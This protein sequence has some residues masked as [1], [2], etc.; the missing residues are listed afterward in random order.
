MRRKPDLGRTMLGAGLSA[1]VVT[2]ASA[3]L[4]QFLYRDCVEMACL[5]VLLFIP[6]AAIG[7]LI[8]GLV[9][10]SRARQGGRGYAAGLLAAGVGFAV[11]FVLIRDLRL[12]AG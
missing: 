8:V 11:M 12:L 4:F 3:G 10:G 5:G 7:S 2:I 6:V 9:A 1:A